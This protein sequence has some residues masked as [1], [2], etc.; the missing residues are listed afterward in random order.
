MERVLAIEPETLLKWILHETD[1]A[2]ADMAQLEVLRRSKAWLASNP[3]ELTKSKT[4]RAQRNVVRPL[5]FVLR[6]SQ[7]VAEDCVRTTSATGKR[8]SNDGGL[9]L[10]LKQLR[11]HESRPPLSCIE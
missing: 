8:M 7:V 10:R 3:W 11:L 4:R 1:P 5:C 2:P 9:E 6:P